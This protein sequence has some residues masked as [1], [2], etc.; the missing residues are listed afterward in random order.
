MTIE[1][2]TTGQQRLFDGND[3][4]AAVEKNDDQNQ[5]VGVIDFLKEWIPVLVFAV[6]IAVVVRMFVVQAFHI[7]SLSMA[8]TLEVGDRV[9][10][11]Q[12]SYRFGEIERGEVIVFSTPPGQ[13]S[14]A[15]DLIKRV[16]A[17]P[18][19][20]LVLRD[21]NVF[22]DGYRLEEPYTLQQNSSRARSQLGIPNCAQP[23]PAPDTCVVPEGYVFV[24]GDNRGGS[25]DSR[26][27]GPVPI[28]SIVGHAFMRV[29]PPNRIGRL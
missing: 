7:P 21:G 20:T 12:L 18:G 25:Q 29:W 2:N 22:I 15:D 16:V 11:N 24:M 14:A 19:E 1:R 23:Q 27:F 5:N 17:L 10:V 6:V 3:S 9:V 26:V 13:P 8:P 4:A 28:D